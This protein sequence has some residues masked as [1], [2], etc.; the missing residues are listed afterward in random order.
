MKGCVYAVVG[1][2]NGV[3]NTGD[4]PADAVAVCLV[5]GSP[6][7]ESEHCTF[8]NKYLRGVGA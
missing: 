1:K 6:S 8:C 4:L 5:C 7:A 2:M 3:N